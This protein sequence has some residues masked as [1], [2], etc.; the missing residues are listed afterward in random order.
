MLYILIARDD[1]DDGYS[2]RWCR[3]KP[4]TSSIGPEVV[5]IPGRL[6]RDGKT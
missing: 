4:R 3:G 6:A 1:D 5:K 2:W